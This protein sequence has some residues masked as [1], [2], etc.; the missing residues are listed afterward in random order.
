MS[1]RRLIASRK[2]SYLP[3]GP[4]NT[5]SSYF[6]TLQSISSITET[7]CKERIVVQYTEQGSHAL[8][9]KTFQKFYHRSTQVSRT[10]QEQTHFAWL[11]RCWKFLQTQFQ[12][13]PGGV[14]TLSEMYTDNKQNWVSPMVSTSCQRNGRKSPNRYRSTD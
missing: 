7:S 3:L 10:F 8:G 13:F 9:Y 11:Y 12:D 6:L 14:G 5:C 4:R 1:L 2:L